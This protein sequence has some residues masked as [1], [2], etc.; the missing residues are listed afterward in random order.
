[1]RDSS[2]N[3]FLPPLLGQKRLQRIARPGVFTEGHALIFIRFDD[4]IKKFVY[5]MNLIDA[6]YACLF[7]C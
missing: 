2:G 7:I 4:L 5:F 6:V 1:M 3:P